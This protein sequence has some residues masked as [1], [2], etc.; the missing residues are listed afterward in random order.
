LDGGALLN[1]P[2]NSTVDEAAQ[3]VQIRLLKHARRRLG[4]YTGE[5]Y[6]RVVLSCLQGTF[7]GIEVDD[8]LGSKLKA[9]FNKTVVDSLAELSQCL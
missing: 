2:S 1:V 4:F 6:Q 9:E 7:E 8:R 3:A 5:K